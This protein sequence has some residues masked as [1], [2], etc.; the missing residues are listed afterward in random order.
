MLKK[1]ALL[2]FFSKLYAGHFLDI[3]G[4]SV[5]TLWKVSKFPAMI[6]MGRE[7]TST[8]MCKWQ[9]QNISSYPRDCTHCPDQ[10]SKA[11]D[12]EDVAV[13]DGGHGDDDPVEGRGDRGEP[14]T[15]LYLNEVAEA[16]NKVGS[17]IFENV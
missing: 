7:R 14:R 17:A 6:G 9:N 2:G 10:L 12:W 8:W 4:A 3:N 11:G 13:A 16:G 15:L 5:S 1:T